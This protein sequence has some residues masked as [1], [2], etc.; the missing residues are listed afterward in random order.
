MARLFVFLSI[1]VSHFL[2]LFMFIVFILIN[3]IIDHFYVFYQ[4]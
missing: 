2:P 4:F 3:I 1:F